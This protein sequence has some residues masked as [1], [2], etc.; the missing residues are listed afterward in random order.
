MSQGDNHSERN[1]PPGEVRLPTRRGRGSN[2]GQ[3]QSKWP[4]QSHSCSSSNVDALAGHQEAGISAPG[5][6]VGG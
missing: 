5:Y 4:C 3:E 1:G 6:V 2:Q